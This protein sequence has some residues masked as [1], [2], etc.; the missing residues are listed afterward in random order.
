MYKVF[1]NDRSLILTNRVSSL[2]G[3]GLFVHS[4]VNEVEL[5]RTI[6]YFLDTDTEKQIL[7]HGKNL[8]ELYKRF[9]ALFFPIEAAGGFVR[10]NRS[11]ILVIRR[12]DKW[13]LP[14]GKADKG[15]RSA[16]TALREVSEECGIHGQVI[17]RPLSA[18]FHI[19]FEKENWCLKKT[20]W[21]EMKYA[22]EEALVPQK[23]EHITEARWIDQ[24]SLPEILKDT[25]PSLLDVFKEALSRTEGPET[26][27]L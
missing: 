13:D 27:S 25:Y 23:S 22:G 26:I 14:K 24:N 19:Y 11:E 10:N 1:F 16:E 20:R 5:K 15:E 6:Q 8:G 7:V 3:E 12:H 2:S 9:E 18:T 4:F 21:F 17:I